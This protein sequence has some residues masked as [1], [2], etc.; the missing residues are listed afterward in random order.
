MFQLTLFDEL[1]K[2][3]KPLELIRF[4]FNIVNFFFLQF[5]FKL[6]FHRPKTKY[7]Y[8]KRSKIP[9]KRKKKTREFWTYR[10][11]ASA[12]T[13]SGADI[14]KLTRHATLLCVDTRQRTPPRART[15]GTCD[16]RRMCD[17]HMHFPFIYLFNIPDGC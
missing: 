11:I 14:G 10:D 5:L 1:K 17:T 9:T 12:P 3:Y 4:L 7:F 13:M 15:R 2:H 8:T 6:S 16:N